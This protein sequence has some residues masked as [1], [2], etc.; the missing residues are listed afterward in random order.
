[1]ADH[2]IKPLGP[3]AQDLTGQT[4][5]RLKVKTF[6]RSKSGRLQ[7]VCIC[8][9]G[10]DATV[11]HENLKSGNT[12]SCGCFRLERTS[13]HRT[14][15]GYSKHCL[16]RTW[17]GM[18][19]RCEDVDDPGYRLYGARGIRVCQSWQ[20]FDQFLADM[21]PIWG[22]GLSIER[23]N[24]DGPYSKENCRFATQQ[25]Q[26]NNTRLSK[27]LTCNGKTLTQAQWSRVMGVKQA[28]IGYRLSA[29]WS[30]ERALA[31]PVHKKPQ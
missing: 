23:I 28:T 17:H 8:S 16:Y 20:K 31:T 4:F 22:P 26:C 1:M 13:E 19:N 10:R 12:R 11:L 7:W 14:T 29:G 5:G 2:C 6:T 15:H 27:R 9:C 30:V 3:R 21:L 25:E 18:K 24:N